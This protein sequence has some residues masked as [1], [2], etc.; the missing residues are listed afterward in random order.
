MASSS[1]GHAG[2]GILDAAVDLGQTAL[3]RLDAAVRTAR[4]RPKAS[5]EVMAAARSVPKVSSLLPPASLISAIG[6]R[7]ACEGGPEPRHSF[8]TTSASSTCNGK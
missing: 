3:Q 6:P 8:R 4:I 5:M 2:L 7:L 1:T